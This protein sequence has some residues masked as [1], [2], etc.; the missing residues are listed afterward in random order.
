MS[1]LDYEAVSRRLLEHAQQTAKQLF[2]Q[3]RTT[4]DRN[5]SIGHSSDVYSLVHRLLTDADFREKVRA[6]ADSTP[7]PG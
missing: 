3:A 1:E 6:L 5:A 4:A 7:A 2:E